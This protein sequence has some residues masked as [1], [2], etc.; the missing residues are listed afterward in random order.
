MS[1]VERFFHDLTE[2]V[3]REGSSDTSKNCATAFLSTRQ[4]AM[5]TQRHLECERL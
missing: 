5:P 4:S 1:L 3:V 2:F